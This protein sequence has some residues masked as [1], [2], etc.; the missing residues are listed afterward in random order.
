MNIVKYMKEDS[1]LYKQYERDIEQFTMQQLLKSRINRRLIVLYQHMLYPEMIDQNVARVLPSVLRSYR[2]RVKNPNIRYVIV[3]Y[4]ELEEEDAYLIQDGVAYVP[5]FLERAVMLFQDAYG[6]RYS[7]VSCRKVPAMDKMDTEK[8]LERCYEVF[9]NHP[10]L[11]LQESGE[12]LE[13][14]IH[15]DSDVMVLRK[16]AADLPLTAM[17]RRRIL[18]DMVRYHTAL[19]RRSDQ[20]RRADAGY[21]LSIDPKRLT[22][23]ERS[24][25]FETLAG[26]KYYTEI[27]D[28]ICEYGSEG[29]SDTCLQNLC[30]WRILKELSG[31]DERML[32]IICGLFE[33]GRCDSVL[34]DYL[35]EHYNGASS[36]MYRILS[37][38]KQDHL[39]VYDL[40][41]RLLAQQ[42]F[43]G[44][45][46]Y[47]DQ[48]FEWY[49]SGKM[50][51][52]SLMKA[53]FT[54]KSADYFLKESETG[55]KV[56]AYLEGAVQ[57]AADLHRI[58]TIYLLALCRYYSDCKGLDEERKTLCA[59]M[60]EVLL[61]E[62]RVFSWYKKLGAFVALP[63]SVMDK[64]ILE[65][66]SGHGGP[67][68]GKPQ[69]MIRIL[70]D[71][72]EFHP[73]AMKR[74]YADIYVSQ[75]VLFAGETMEY[76]IYEN[77]NG[78]DVLKTY[79][80]ISPQN[81]SAAGGSRY[82]ALNEMCLSF[83]N[84]QEDT[85]KEKMKKY[86][87]DD[88]TVGSLFPLQ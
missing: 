79:G 68:A 38:G 18:S 13:K 56:F 11:R 59:R 47:L 27:W 60:I 26:Q 65:Y 28:R 6:N 14:G 63:E 50:R 76:Q 17:Y 34:L 10:M 71:E 7:D 9:P 69:M 44:E 51:G 20:P 36:M 62:E 73:E 29:L 35:C 1:P 24:S 48:V 61:E 39:E 78:E 55:D 3:R 8:L 4:E 77:E 15:D 43:T 85:L 33:R 72:E 12:V 75:K 23:E 49:A 87:T 32:S 45:T 40:P 67:S 70:P 66:R 84:R 21:L 42:L 31:E 16:I 19:L 74:V 25:V 64:T 2:I 81:E 41:E 57:N 80:S 88:E 22:K 46:K 30:S 53:Y 52:E 58:P 37:R 83:E 54:K 86:L 5:L 82:A